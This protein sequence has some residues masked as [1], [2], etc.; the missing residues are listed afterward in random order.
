M[1]LL[2]SGQNCDRFETL[3]SYIKNLRDLRSR[4]NYTDLATPFAGEFSVNFCG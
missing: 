4:A 2:E 3:Y 1:V